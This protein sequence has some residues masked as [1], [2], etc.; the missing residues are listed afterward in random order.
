MDPTPT[1]KSPSNSLLLSS[2]DIAVIGNSDKVFYPPEVDPAD[3]PDGIYR[4]DLGFLL[5][6]TPSLD[7]VYMRYYAAFDQFEHFLSPFEWPY[8]IA[9]LADG[10]FVICGRANESAQS[11]NGFLPHIWLF[12]T[13]SLGCIEPGCQNIVGLQEQVIGLQ[14][15]MSVYPNPLPA[16]GQLTL[17]F[18]PM[19]AGTM[20]YANEA[21]KLLVYDLQGR[22]IHQESLPQRGDNSGFVYRLDLPALSSGQYIVHWMSDAGAWYDSEQVLVE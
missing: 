8:D 2:G 15:S 11:D 4:N 3:F 1:N 7:S 16:G 22:L 20:P 10:G 17:R 5:R 9:E 14:G 18:E 21:T 13:D 12:R 6:L 19:P